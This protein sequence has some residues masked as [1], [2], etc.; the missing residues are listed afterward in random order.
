MNESKLGHDM[1][2]Y[3]SKAMSDKAVDMKVTTNAVYWRDNTTIK[4]KVS[5]RV[6]LTNNAGHGIPDG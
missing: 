6:A 5:V 3:R 2:S 4:P 1:Q